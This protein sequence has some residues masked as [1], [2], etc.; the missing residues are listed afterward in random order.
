[1]RDDLLKGPSGEIEGLKGAQ[2]EDIRRRVFFKQ[3][4]PIWLGDL[5]TEA[6]FLH[7]LAHDFSG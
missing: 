4:D 1:L 5:G 2:A 7:H 3:N 6:K